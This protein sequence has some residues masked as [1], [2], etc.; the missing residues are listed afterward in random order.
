MKIQNLTTRFGSR[1]A[2][3]GLLAWC[4]SC[5]TNTN[6]TTSTTTTTDV[7]N[8]TLL[9]AG[10]DTYVVTVNGNGELDLTLTSFT[11]QTTITLGLGV[12]IPSGTTC[13][14]VTG[15]ENAKAGQTLPASVGPGSYC[16]V[17]YDVGNVQSSDAFTLTVV[18]P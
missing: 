5:A 9:P 14:L 7:F 18:H 1:L 13:S 12:G 10:T 6:P 4:C 11:P 3:A 16:V 15:V 8:G 2:L 17:I